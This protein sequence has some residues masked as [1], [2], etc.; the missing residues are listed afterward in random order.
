M[1]IC[2]RVVST[3]TG[4]AMVVGIHTDQNC[5]PTWPA[6]RR[7][8]SVISRVWSAGASLARGSLVRSLLKSKASTLPANRSR[9][10]HGKS[11]WPSISGVLASTAATRACS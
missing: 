3:A 5:P 10:S 8:I 6:R 9:T 7:G 11:L 4:P 2:W 1:S